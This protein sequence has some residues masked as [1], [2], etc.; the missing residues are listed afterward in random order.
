[1]GLGPGDPHPYLSVFLAADSNFYRWSIHTVPWSTY[2]ARGGGA[3][4]AAANVD[5]I[6][7]DELVVG[8]TEGGAGWLAVMTPGGRYDAYSLRSWI[9]VPWPDYSE[10]VGETFPAAGNLDDDPAEE[11]VVALGRTGGGW[12]A[13][14]DDEI[15]GHQFLGW[16]R[17]PWAAYNERAGILHPAIADVDGDAREEI[18]LGLGELR[19]AGAWIEIRDDAEARYASLAWRKAFA[20]TVTATFPAA[21]RLFDG[22]PVQT[23]GLAVD[24][25]RPRR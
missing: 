3:H 16:R 23:A 9:R 5:G 11:I 19:G 10:R 22:V 2:V 6:G 12:F 17:L 18:V 15:A 20:Q 7:T 13:I 25:T 14:F 4:P 24:M 1:M 21:G 8:L